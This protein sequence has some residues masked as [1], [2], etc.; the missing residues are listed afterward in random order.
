METES[1]GTWS[2]GTKSTPF[3]GHAWRKEENGKRKRHPYQVQNCKSES[4]GNG[5][6]AAVVVRVCLVPGTEVVEGVLEPAT[7]ARKT[8]RNHPL[9]LVQLQL[10]STKV[11]KG[12]GRKMVEEGVDWEEREVGRAPVGSR[13]QGGQ[14]LVHLQEAFARK[15]QKK[16]GTLFVK[17]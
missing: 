10:C 6:T 16:R 11:G 7:S 17:R 8:K 5:N 9:V 14:H 13:E 3:S 15:D 2:P 12:R 4:P 1:S